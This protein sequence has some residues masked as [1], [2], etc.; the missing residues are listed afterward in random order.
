ME[1]NA[2]TALAVIFA[3]AFAPGVFWLYYFYKKDKLEP[4]PKKLL[5]KMFLFGVLSTIP[6]ILVEVPFLLLPK[7][8]SLAIVAPVAEEFCK[9]A[10]VKWTIYKHKEFDE[11]MDGI[12][13]AAAVALGFASLENVFYFLQSERLLLVFAARALLS[14]PAHA[15]WS[16]MWGYALG[17]A[18]FTH[19]P[20]QKKRLVRRGLILSMVFHGLFNFFL[21]WN[22]IGLLLFAILVVAMWIMIRKKIKQALQLSPY[23]PPRREGQ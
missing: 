17:V 6:A 22:V 8:I 13:Y 11:P 5:I 21:V 15:I 19:D 2:L 9:Y 12:V 7:I 14:V 23:H 18:K 3:L 16:S 20:K 1:P 4:E 10:T